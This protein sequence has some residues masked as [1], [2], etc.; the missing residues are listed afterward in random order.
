MASIQYPDN[1]RGPLVSEYSRD[2]VVGFVEENVAA[3]PSFVTPISEDTP[4]FHT[5]TYRFKR[6]DARRFESWLKQNQMKFKSPWFN[7]PI[8]HPDFAAQ[9]AQE[10]RYLSDGY[11]QLTGVSVGGLF[12]YTAR[13]ITRSI[14]TQDDDYPTELDALHGVNCGNINSGA[15]DLDIGFNG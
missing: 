6:G 8:I 14:V 12:T 2:E 13:V 9:E 15:N 4:Q 7:G 11:P 10:C 1:L 5:L 3:G